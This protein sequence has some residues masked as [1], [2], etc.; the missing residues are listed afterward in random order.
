[1]ANRMT[2]RPERGIEA[3]RRYVAMRDAQP[4]N[5]LARSVHRL[6]V[7]LDMVRGGDMAAACIWR[8]AV[9]FTGDM[10]AMLDDLGIEPW[11]IVV[12][13]LTVAEVY[14]V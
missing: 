6:R 8:I 12:E 13:H 14:R 1:M 9:P 11:R 10:Q 7:G 2:D 3:I 5:G 4:L